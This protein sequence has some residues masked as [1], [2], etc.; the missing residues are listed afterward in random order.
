M[1]VGE[2]KYLRHF[3]QQI[4]A[5]NRE[6]CVADLDEAE[7]PLEDNLLL[8]AEACAAQLIGTSVADDALLRLVA[9]EQAL[10]PK[11]TQHFGLRGDALDRF[12][13]EVLGGAL[14]ERLFE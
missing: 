10:K 11:M 7:L 14:R 6:K 12:F 9:Q 5:L 1:K 8:T 2:L 13:V 4:A 3:I